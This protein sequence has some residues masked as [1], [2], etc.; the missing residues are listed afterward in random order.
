[1]VPRMLEPNKKRLMLNVQREKKNLYYIMRP[2]VSFEAEDKF[3]K[4]RAE[5]EPSEADVKDM[6]EKVSLEHNELR[7]IPMRNHYSVTNY[8]NTFERD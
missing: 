8:Y 5:T 4:W 6:L 7:P 2:A 1:M 3:H